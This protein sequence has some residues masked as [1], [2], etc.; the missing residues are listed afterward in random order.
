MYPPYGYSYNYGRPSRLDLEIQDIKNDYADRIKS[1][2]M[3]KAMSG[4]ERRQE[5]RDLKAERDKAILDAQRSYHY[6]RMAPR[7]QQPSGNGNSPSNDNRNN[8]NNSNDNG[9]NSNSS[10]NG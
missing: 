5:I 2:R 3:D 9:D 1:V 6:R 7:S 10:Y 8:N 4:R